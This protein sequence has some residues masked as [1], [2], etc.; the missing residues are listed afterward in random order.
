MDVA[1]CCPLRWR[2]VLAMNVTALPCCSAI[3]FTPCLKTHVHVRHRQRFGVD[4]IDLV[5]AA[6]PLALAAF[7][8][9]ARRGHAVADGAHERLVARRLHDVV[10]NA[11][12]AGRLQVAV[13]GGEG[14]VVG[15]VEEVELQLAGA[16]AGEP[17]FAELIELPSQ[18]RPRRFRHQRCRRAARNRRTTSAAPGCQGSTRS[19]DRSGRIAKSP[20]PVSQLATLNPSSG[21]MS[22][23]TVSR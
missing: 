1:D 18:D 11:V 2:R 5:L 12:I 15:L 9:H 6:A 3:S 20:K 8:R 19:V 23:F 22:M 16:V 21:S 13:A 4:E 17:L 14:R 7:D 10:I